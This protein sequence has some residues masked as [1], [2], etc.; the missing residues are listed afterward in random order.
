MPAQPELVLYSLNNEKGEPGRGPAEKIRV[1]LHECG[2]KYDN[3]GLSE[4]E[5]KQMTADETLKSGQLPALKVG[6]GDTAVTYEMPLAIM[7]FLATLADKDG[8]GARGNKYCGLP[9]EQ[10]VV[11]CIGQIAQ[12]FEDRMVTSTDKTGTIQ[13][14]FGLIQGYLLRNDDG[15]DR[16][17]EY[18]YGKQLTWADIACFQV[19]NEAV[20]TQ[21]MG[22]LREF[23]K[24]KDFHDMI[25]GRAR[26]TIHLS[27]RS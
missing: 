12:Q 21:G 16:T 20:E 1:M 6:K 7:E 13:H 17:D 10:H 3:V 5:V 26:I 15:D 4:E 19:V 25:A 18:T 14:Y 27:Q 8:K 23:H 2:Y 22:R 24:L 11:R 9:E